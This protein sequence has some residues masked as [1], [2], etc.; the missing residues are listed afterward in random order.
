MKNLIEI[1][2]DNE[3]LSKVKIK[4]IFINGKEIEFLLESS[5]VNYLATLDTPNCSVY[6]ELE[7]DNGNRL[8][9]LVSFQQVSPIRNKVNKIGIFTSKN[10]YN[11]KSSTEKN[12]PQ[13]KKGRYSFTHPND[14]VK[15]KFLSEKGW[16]NNKKWNEIYIKMDKKELFKKDII[17]PR[18]DDD[19][20]LSQNEEYEIFFEG[21]NRGFKE[22]EIDTFIKESV[23]EKDAQTHIQR[24]KEIQKKICILII[25]LILTTFLVFGIIKFEKLNKKMEKKYESITK[26]IETD[27]KIN[28][29]S[30]KF[31]DESIKN[32]KLTPQIIMIKNN[33]KSDVIISKISVGEGFEFSYSENEK[34][35]DVLNNIMIKSGDFKEI[36]IRF[37]PE[38]IKV[39]DNNVNVYLGENIHTAIPVIGRA[40]D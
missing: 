7:L 5:L 19:K 17:F 33:G 26:K 10:I 15:D 13:I 23:A 9:E 20:F 25:F 6:I 11:N 32:K 29:K 35:E 27:L 22:E 18:L 34:W 16:G 4:V 12:I 28:P 8:K 36:Y 2:Q 24:K 14:V 21:K 31:V 3:D 1:K 37:N 40:L 30:I 38:T 39:Y